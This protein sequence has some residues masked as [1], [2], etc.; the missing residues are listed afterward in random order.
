[1]CATSARI[2]TRK[3]IS[4]ISVCSALPRS[5]LGKKKLFALSAMNTSNRSNI[6]EN[7]DLFSEKKKSAASNRTVSHIRTSRILESKLKVYSDSLYV[8]ANDLTESSSLRDFLLSRCVCRKVFFF[9]CKTLDS[10][11]Y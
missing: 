1:M 6:P 2:G 11:F 9:F 8:L 5:D 10:R 7:G 3:L 4:P